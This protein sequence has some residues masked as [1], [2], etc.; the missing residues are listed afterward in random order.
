MV[1]QVYCY[2][3]WALAAAANGAWALQLFSWRGLGFAAVASVTVVSLI[4]CAVM[5][6]LATEEKGR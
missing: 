2:P 6:A 1:S 3:I 5:L 4:A